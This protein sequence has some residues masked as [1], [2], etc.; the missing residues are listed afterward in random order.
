[1]LTIKS[2]KTSLIVKESEFL[3]HCKLIV[4]RFFVVLAVLNSLRIA[5]LLCLK[6]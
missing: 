6:F 4:L 5:L 3:L 2:F 1:M